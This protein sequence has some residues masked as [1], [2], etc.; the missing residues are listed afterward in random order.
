MNC[1]LWIAL[2][3]LKCSMVQ[4]AASREIQ[5]LC[6][7]FQELDHNA[8]ISHS[9]IAIVMNLHHRIILEQMNK[10]PNGAQSFRQYHLIIMIQEMNMSPCDYVICAFHYRGTWNAITFRAIPITFYVINWFHNVLQ[11]QV[12]FVDWHIQMFMMHTIHQMN[13]SLI[14]PTQPSTKTT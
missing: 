14:T 1:S 10:Q 8:I 4:K 2:L 5:L 12:S 3:Q 6:H 9:T 7:N 11:C 13:P